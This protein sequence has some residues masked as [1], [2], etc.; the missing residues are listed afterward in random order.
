MLSNCQERQKNYSSL[1]LSAKQGHKLMHFE[2]PCLLTTSSTA[3]CVHVYIVFQ[4]RMIKFNIG[5]GH[6][7]TKLWL[8]YATLWKCHTVHV[9]DI[10]LP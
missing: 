2:Q 9:G 8:G 4:L 7:V 3:L 5:K 10:Y 1:L 6:Q